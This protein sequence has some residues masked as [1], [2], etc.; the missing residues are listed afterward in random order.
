MQGTGGVR[1]VRWAKDKGKS[2]G[3]RTIYID[4]TDIERIYFITVFGKHEKTNLTN[5][6]KKIIKDFVKSIK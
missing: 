3:K 1:K 5:E 6:E 2:G 4:F